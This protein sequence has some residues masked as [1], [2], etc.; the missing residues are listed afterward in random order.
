MGN[1]IRLFKHSLFKK[2]GPVY[3]ITWSSLLKINIDYYLDIPGSRKDI[4]SLLVMNFS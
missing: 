4:Y 1:N 2:I 3:G